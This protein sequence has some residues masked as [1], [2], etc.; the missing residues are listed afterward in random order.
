[1]IIHEIM[2]SELGAGYL[3]RLSKINGY[4]NKKITIE[5]LRKEFMRMD[6]NANISISILLSRAL[7][8]STEQFC[9]FHTI[10][11]ALRSVTSHLPYIRHGDLSQPQLIK[12]NTNFLFRNEF[13]ACSKCVQED[14]EYHGFSYYR[15]EHQ[16]P[17]FDFCSKHNQK[18]VK[19]ESE[20]SVS[21]DEIKL[22]GGDSS[23]DCSNAFS[24]TN[25]S[26]INLQVVA[27]AIQGF[28][29]GGADALRNNKIENFNFSNL[30]AAFDTAGA[31]AN[32]QLTDA[33]LTTHLQAGSD[34]AAIGGDLA[35][36]YG[37]NSNLTGMGLLNAQS[38]IA[39][40]SFG[41]AAQTL[42]N[43]TVWQA[44]V[45]KLG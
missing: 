1:M 4:I 26:V 18:L 37:K 28:T 9:R 31:T 34:T 15:R 45:A 38:V 16:L 35:Y 43:P 10:L 42:N 7:G 24:P 5:K 29:L 30:V 22:L 40:A 2:P 8:I 17:G 21:P 14:I 3:I 41:Q 32:W 44:E 23:K 11:P 39:A 20:Y 25:K 19:S 13:K 33:R 36:Q 12:T 6:D 27:E